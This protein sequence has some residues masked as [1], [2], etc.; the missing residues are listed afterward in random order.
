M[1]QLSFVNLLSSIFFILF[2]RIEDI[3]RLMNTKIDIVD[4]NSFERQ[5]SS[6]SSCHESETSQSGS[7][8]FSS[9][10]LY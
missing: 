10:F 9:E 6:S 1:M 2:Q 7:D 4:E 5:R 8:V 3:D